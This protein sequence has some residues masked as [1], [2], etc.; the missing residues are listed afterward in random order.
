M[1][2]DHSHVRSVAVEPGE[3]VGPV[4]ETLVVVTGHL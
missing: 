2:I 4:A 3:L 1:T